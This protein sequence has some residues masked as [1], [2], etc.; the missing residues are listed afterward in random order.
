[1]NIYS[2]FILPRVVHCVCGLRPMMMQ[3]AKV[4]PMARGIVLEL[5][6]GSGL[7]VP[8]YDTDL[9]GHLIGVDPTPHG[10]RL[11]QALSTTSISTEMHQIPAEQLSLPPAS[12][13]TIVSTY[14]LCT[15]PDIKATLAMCHSVLKRE[16]QFL[17]VEHG[18]AEDKKV[19]SVQDKVNPVWKRIAGGCHLNRDIPAMM[20]EA[21]F[22]WDTMENMYLPGWRPATWNVWGRLT[23]Q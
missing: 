1:M 3:R 6:I 20:L 2:T 7:N 16:G 18:A 8:Y 4:V 12:V 19:R 17:L 21:G 14:T 23:K 22:K 10:T 15:I 11:R 5:G 13:D 9:V